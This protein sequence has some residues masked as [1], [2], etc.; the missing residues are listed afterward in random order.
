MERNRYRWIWWIVAVL[1]LAGLIWYAV[2]QDQNEDYTDGTLVW[3]P[4]DDFY[5]SNRNYC[6]LTS[7]VQPSIS[8][9]GSIPVCQKPSI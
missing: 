4:G 5:L 3:N 9:E 1:I 8:C 7:I 2:A 6:H